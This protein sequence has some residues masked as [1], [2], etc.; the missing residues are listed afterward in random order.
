METQGIRI[1]A[2][3]QVIEVGLHACDRAR[4]VLDAA[5]EVRYRPVD[6]SLFFMKIIMHDLATQL[7]NLP[8]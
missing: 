1:N 5:E 2:R 7:V 8:P 4:A 6:R 3:N